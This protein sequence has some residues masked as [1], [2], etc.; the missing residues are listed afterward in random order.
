MKAERWEIGSEFHWMGLPQGP[1]I[2]LPRAAVW[3]SLARHAIRE[4]LAV[5]RTNTLWIPEYFCEDVV[6]HLQACCDV[7]RY[8]DLPTQAE[9][10]W[11]TLT[12]DAGDLVLAVDYFGMRSPTGWYKWAPKRNWLLLE[13]YSHDPAYGFQHS[14]ADY[15]IASLRKTLPVPDGALLWS[16][17]GHALPRP[18]TGNPLGTEEKFAAMIWKLEYLS[19]CIEEKHKEVFRNWQVHGEQLLCQQ[20]V[21]APSAES[22]ALCSQGIPVAWLQQ[23]RLNVEYLLHELRDDVEAQS[24]PFSMRDGST[25]YAAV[26]Q[27]KSHATRERAREQ[28]LNRRI[29]CPVHWPAGIGSSAAA[30][31]LSATLLTLVSDQ[32]YG[33]E[34]MKRII[35]TLQESIER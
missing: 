25:P 32:R 13:D 34:D 12:P 26:L 30:Q 18:P 10:A 27:F 15:A 16:P 21:S 4:L 7:R 5:C 31:D 14:Q 20:P 23:R 29:Y 24:V 35:S 1:F 17:A 22:M 6:E 3:Y 9:P 8:L 2:A 33:I 28:L 19:G 11:E